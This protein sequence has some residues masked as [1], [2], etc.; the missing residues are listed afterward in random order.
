MEKDLVENEQRIPDQVASGASWAVYP[1][2]LSSICC[3]EDLVQDHR[4][5]LIQIRVDE[6]DAQ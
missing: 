3:I 1:Q 2:I 6:Y 5:I 4:L